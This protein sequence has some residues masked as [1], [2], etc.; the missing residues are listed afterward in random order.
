MVYCTYHAYAKG[1]PDNI[2][3]GVDAT[4]NICGTSGDNTEDAPYLYFYNPK[5]LYDYRYCVDKCPNWDETEVT[6]IEYWD[7]D[8]MEPLTYN[9]QIDDEGNFVSGDMDSVT[10]G[11]VIGYDSSIALERFCMP[12]SKV[13][14]DA[15]GDYLED[16]TG[17]LNKGE[18][19]NLVT[20]VKNVICNINKELAMA[21]MRYW[22]CSCGIIDFHVPAAL[23]CGM[24]GM[25]IHHTD[26]P[27]FRWNR[28]HLSL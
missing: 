18:F 12:S 10:A 20:D 26:N 4:G 16:F 7:G 13:L 9:Y 21:I 23:Y 22:V 19:A 28:N 6:A 3:R 24:C 2:Y 25:G 27:S 14:S 17:A 15:F 5:D 11:Q 8:S 1:N